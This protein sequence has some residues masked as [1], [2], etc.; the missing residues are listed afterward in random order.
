MSVQTINT[1][2]VFEFERREAHLSSDDGHDGPPYTIHGIALGAG[3]VTHGSSGVKKLWPGEE[4]KE[5]AETL[6]DKNLVVDHDNTV[7][8]VVGRV[9]KAGYKDD[10]GVIYEAELFDES[11]VNK[12]KDGLLEVSIRG[13]HTDVDEM[14][15]DAE[16][17]AKVVSDIEFDNLSIVPNG[18]SPSNT[19]EMGEHA[20]LSVEE[21][22]AFTD[23]LEKAELQ[24]I[25]ASDFVQWNDG[26]HGIV[27][28]VSGDTATVEVMEKVDE[29]WRAVG[30]Q[31][32]VMLDDLSMWDV[33]ESDVGGPVKDDETSESSGRMDEEEDEEEEEMED[34]QHRETIEEIDNYLQAEGTSD[35]PISEFIAWTGHDDD[36]QETAN[37]YVNREDNSFQDPVSE[38]QSWLS[39]V[40]NMEEATEDTELEGSVHKPDWSGTDDNDWS[41]PS[42][43]EFASGSWDELPS[44]RKSSIGEHFIFSMTGFPAENF[45]DMKLPIVR[46]NGT[47][48]LSAVRNAK[49]RLSQTDGLSSE[50]RSRVE[51]M[52]DSILEDNSSDEEAGDGE[53]VSEK[54]GDDSRHSEEDAEMEGGNGHMFSSEQEAM[55]MAEEIGISGAH[56]MGD[57]WMPGETHQAYLDAVAQAMGHMK[58]D[59]EEMESS[60]PEIT[61]V[62]VL[63]SDDLWQSCK[64][65]KSEMDSITELQVINM[66]EISDELKAQLE[67]LEEPTAVEAGDLEELKNKATMYDDISEDISE[68]RERTDVLDSVDRSL[69]DE[70]A[71]ADEPMVIESSR[72][73]SLS[74]E[75]EQV[76]KVYAANLSEEVEF[77]DADELV[78]KFSI[79]ELRAKHDEHVGELEEEL[80]PDP[81]GGDMSEEELEEK[82]S[83]SEKDEAELE[84]E[85]EVAARQ[86]ELR[87]RMRRDRRKNN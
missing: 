84:K 86:E 61:G 7:S 19:L 87:A 67:Q 34:P 51:S 35:M 55:D 30:T 20:E 9:T 43:S 70:L 58:K 8:G 40:M 33:D 52:L 65:G 71:E 1:V 85:E 14:E 13:Y 41:K 21:L 4:L 79:E 56:K 17:G 18:A 32:E 82:A 5:A 28:K 80:S 3:D 72:Y 39:K 38:F 31:A 53:S 73:E 44:E 59:D 50:Q 68:L 57:M 11:L 48:S 24:E 15:D 60:V 36:V 16:T 46:P 66:T 83:E 75:A 77:F 49:S 45:S 26:K 12:V 42:L 69:V 76:K 2:D 29:K 23:T 6:E 62:S 64:S 27:F 81:K 78:E 37:E 63:T 74:D 10:V 22:T 47:L 25:E 54:G